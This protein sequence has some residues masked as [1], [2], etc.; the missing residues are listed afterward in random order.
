MK[1]LSAAIALVAIASCRGAELGPGVP[2]ALAFDLLRGSHRSIYRVRS[3]GSDTLCLTPD[4]AD[5]RQPTSAAGTI[6]FV[7]SRDGNAELYSMPNKGGTATRLTFTTAN[8]ADPALSPDGTK[9]AY[10]RDDGGLPR[11]WIGNADASGAVRVTDSLD[12]GGAVDASPAWGPAS[13]KVVF[14]STTSGSARLYQ[15][16]LAGMTIAPVLSDTAPDVE[17]SVSPEGTLLAFVSGANGGA[18]VAML[19][20]AQHKVNFLTTA[21]A[22][23]GQPTWLADSAIVFLQRGAT[24]ALAVINPLAPLTVQLIDVGPGTPG[25]PAP[26]RPND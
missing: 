10:T 7:S 20:V 14:V 1:R 2:P 22:Q 4:S 11:L 18:R 24:P 23:N 25:H 15:L 16:T 17:P 19:D 13:D 8:E 6:V 9:L 21:G 5:N 12:F 26:I 3:D